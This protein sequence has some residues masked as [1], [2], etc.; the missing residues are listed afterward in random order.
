[1]QQ[2]LLDLNRISSFEN[3]LFF[4]K[5][6]SVLEMELGKSSFLLLP[7]PVRSV[8]IVEL[9]LLSVRRTKP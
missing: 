1:M 7:E 4:P 9:F 2:F 3:D 8:A 5:S 6:L